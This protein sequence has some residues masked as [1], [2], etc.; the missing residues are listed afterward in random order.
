MRAWPARI[1]YLLLLVPIVAVL[2]V[3]QG[4]PARGAPFGISGGAWPA[5]GHDIADTRNAAGEH[6][7]GPGNVSRLA[8][9]WR[10]T[11]T[12][13]VTV[14]PT[15]ADGT[16]YF[17]DSGGTL[18]AVAADSGRVRWSH[19][20]SE[21]TGIAGDVSRTSPAVYG[22]ELVFG[23]TSV[24]NGAS[25]IAVDRR[26]GRL[27]WRTLV[28]PHAAAIMTGAAVIYRG[29]VYEG[30][31]SAE[32]VLATTPGYKCCSFRGSVVALDAATGKLLWK[33][34]T[35]P[36][37]Y[38]G[39]P[40]W[41][42]TPAID[43]EDNLVY[44]GTGNNYTA[45]PGVCT[46]PGE[47]GCAPPAAADHAD[48][49]LA[50]DRTTGAVRWFK[51]TLSS[52]VYT[53]VCGDHPSGT[54]G[55]DFDFGSGPNLIRLPSGRQILG[56]GQKNGIYWALDARTGAPVWQTIVGPGSSLGG[57]EW[58]SA[59]DGRR[60]YA[61]ISNFYRQ[62]YVITSAD[63]TT[64]TSSGGFW[65]ALDAATGK[66][67]WQV[68][69]PQGAADMGYVSSANGVVYAGSTAP[70]GTNMYA[71]DAASGRILWRFSSGGSVASGAAIAGGR[72]YWGSGYLLPISCPAPGVALSYCPTGN[73]KFYA[74]TRPAP[75][76]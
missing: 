33:T 21:Y 24:G 6:G 44:V 20:V 13:S 46:V 10:L 71:L 25:V 34:Y 4:T 45:P 35:V 30:V 61:A 15:V 50:L 53:L 51:S 12:G 76:R 2:L 26:T 31:S 9:A 14:T 67:L 47:T 32:E 74:F 64:S 19:H 65:A 52:D 7:V 75:R 22:D 68:A 5:A 41:G 73:D 39:G 27:R 54:C 37:G 16:V 48:S 56:I 57:I 18:W 59:T 23:D 43:P 36:A 63:G 62:P 8:P 55:P 42:S 3:A 69:D 49:I 28:E 38:S 17:P 70:T 72:V 11:T 29:V 58:G 60:V 1:G 40:V 66:I